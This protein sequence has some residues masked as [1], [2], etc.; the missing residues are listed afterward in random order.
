M[1]LLRMIAFRPAGEQS[2]ARAPATAGGA[3]RPAPRA[4]SPGTA[5]SSG[6][7]GSPG[8]A[9]ATSGNVADSAA[10][11]ATAA[12]AA[13][14]WPAILG[15]LE[16]SGAARQLA[17]HCVFI[18]RQGAVVRLALDP[19]NQLVRTAA[20]EEKLAQALSRHFGQTVRLEFQAGTAPGTETPAQAQRRASEAELAAARRAFEE[21]PGVRSLRDRFGATVLPDTIRPVK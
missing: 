11:T 1:T 20:T 10:S 5:G 12:S 17:N 9:E 3:A 4:G 15:Q 8:R 2:S 21:D 7:A 16:L 6:T 14:G 13:D 19:R 18:G